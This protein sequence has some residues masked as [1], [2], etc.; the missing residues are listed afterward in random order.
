[1]ESFVLSTIIGYVFTASP[2]RMVFKCTGFAKQYIV[3]RYLT[4]T[5][6]YSYSFIRHIYL[7]GDCICLSMSSFTHMSPYPFQ[8]LVF[9]I[10]FK[11]RLEYTEWYNTEI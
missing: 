5:V 6:I 4:V 10:H 3:K 7:K 9:Y 1:M 8:L 11:F 2:Q